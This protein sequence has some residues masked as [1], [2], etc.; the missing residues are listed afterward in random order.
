MVRRTFG[1]AFFLAAWCQSTQV[2]TLTVRNQNHEANLMTNRHFFLL[3][4]LFLSTLPALALA[5]RLDG[6]DGVPRYG[7]TLALFTGLAL[8]IKLPVFWRAGLY[9]RYWRYASVD[10]LGQIVLAVLLASLLLN[11]VLY[12]I[13]NPFVLTQSL[14]TDPQSLTPPIP[15]SLGALDFLLTLAAVGGTRFAVRLAARYRQRSLGMRGEQPVLVIGAGDAGQM[16]VR[17]MQANPRLGMIPVGF[18]DDDP[19]KQGL[20]I[21]G[22]PVLGD[23][24]RIAELAREY[25]ASQVVIAMPTA[26]GKVIREILHTCEQA[27][28]PVRTVPGIYEILNGQVTVNQIRNV[29]FEDLL[30]RAP[31][32]IDTAAVRGLIAG[33]RVLVTGAGGSI[34]SELCR[35]IAQYDPAQLVL[36]GHGEHSIFQ[37]ASEFA[38]NHP[39]VPIARVIADV[40]DAH[41]L[42]AV[43]ARYRPQIV[44]HAAAHK[45]LPLME[46]NLEDAVSNNVLGTRNTLQAAR[47][48][49]V[50]RFVFISSDKAVNPTSVMGVTKR[51]AEMMVTS[52]GGAEERRS[53]GAEEPGRHLSTSAPPLLCTAV[54][55][56]N[57]LG[58]RGSVVHVFR[59]QIARG[60]PV[61]V[62]HPEMQRYFMTIPE[63]AQLVLQAAALGQGGEVFVLD[64]GEPVKI[65][66]MARELI[67][68]SGLQVGRDIDIVFT[69]IRPGEKLYEELFLPNDHYT[70]TQHDKIFVCR[71]GAGETE[72]GDAGGKG[73]FTE[74]VDAL[75]AAAQRGNPAEVRRRLREIVLEYK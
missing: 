74:Q 30:R 5:L 53:A 61:T 12:V 29:Q 60:G 43:F 23:R 22:V 26:P 37:L 9:N 19:R 70:R 20:R 72:S 16:I 6:F 25:Q 45:H 39:Q 18:V 24:R 15:R 2:S 69:G 63:A 57:V 32:Q 11:L 68:L 38:Q 47:E 34:G 56:G 44:F 36:L 49:G 54:R 75:I 10:D 59:E 66:D 21:H 35:Q 14:V 1:T 40:R 27:G 41:R 33:Q 64:M 52:G 50:E 28:L 31:V 58:S 4:I 48:H 42:D 67:E 73:R 62:T 17:E 3:D 46:E 51:V 7:L 55:F 13:V 65:V 8:T 71:N